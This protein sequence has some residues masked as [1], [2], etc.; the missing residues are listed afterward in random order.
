MF[1]SHTVIYTILREDTHK[2]AHACTPAQT[3]LPTHAVTRHA[4]VSYR[5]FPQL[6]RIFLLQRTVR[7]QQGRQRTAKTV[8][9]FQ[10]IND[11]L[12]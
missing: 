10:S 4:R 7:R 11:S 5:F 8:D 2:C 1:P 6:Q 3:W 12:D 9:P